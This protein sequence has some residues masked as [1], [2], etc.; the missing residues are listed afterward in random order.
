M[1]VWLAS[2]PKSGNTLLRALLSSY[3]FS[4]DGKFDFEMIENIKQFPKKALF[5]KNGVD[6][7]NEKEVIKNYLKVQNPLIL[8]ILLNF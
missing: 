4:N 8:K 2:Y 3:F 6:T 1:F 5:T 7:K